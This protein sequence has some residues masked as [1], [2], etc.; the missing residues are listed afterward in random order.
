MFWGTLNVV[1]SQCFRLT[2]AATISYDHGHDTSFRYNPVSLFLGMPG[3]NS[4]AGKLGIDCAPAMVGFDFHGGRAHPMIGENEDRLCERSKV[5]EC[6]LLDL[7][8]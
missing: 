3:L 5:C 4:I 1:I 2:E 8:I 7:Q 6:L